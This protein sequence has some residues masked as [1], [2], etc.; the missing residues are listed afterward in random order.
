MEGGAGMEKHH[1]TQ[2]MSNQ[3]SS[4]QYE[5]HKNQELKDVYS[6]IL[7]INQDS[8]FCIVD[9][10]K[11]AQQ[12]AIALKESARSLKNTIIA[13]GRLDHNF[14]F[15]KK[16]AFSTNPSLAI[17]S[18]IGNDKQNKILPSFTISVKSLA[19]PQINKGTFLPV[20]GKI[21]LSPNTY[22]F[23]LS[24][25][26]LNYEFQFNINK[27]ETHEV[28]LKRLAR[29]INNAG[30]GLNAYIIFDEEQN[31]A[32]S[33]SSKAIGLSDH[34]SSIF[35]I[36][37]QN[38]SRQTGVV[39]YLGL[40]QIATPASNACFALNGKEQT[41]SVNEFTVEKLFHITLT[42]TSSSPED[43]AVISIKQDAESVM[44]NIQI[45]IDSYHHFVKTAESYLLSH[46]QVAKLIYNMKSITNQH[47]TELKNMG[48]FV[49]TDGK[50][51]LDRDIFQDIT[52]HLVSGKLPETTY[53]AALKAFAEAVLSKTNDVQLNPMEYV[54]RKTV[55]YKN[56]EAPNYP[57]PYISSQYS[58]M[59][60][61]KF[62]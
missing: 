62:C 38:T 22:S 44:E 24:I 8:P 56:P 40:N 32:L 15:Q 45:F 46:P 13:L 30:I 1:S 37:D 47:S 41:A 7:R 25:N 51:Y 59:M 60:Y 9:T 14:L 57:C 61:N 52:S 53:F 34:Q 36:S 42:G 2:S 10:S 18:Y 17:A 20:K 16:M 28:L 23:D 29:L 43:V 50:L 48:I 31:C 39:A 58:G 54:D 21:T 11:N 49:Q 3:Y 35:S 5:A 27:G 26:S 6:S 4:Y 19:T 55:E 33:I 12:F